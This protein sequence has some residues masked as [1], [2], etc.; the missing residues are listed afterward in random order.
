MLKTVLDAKNGF[1]SLL[2]EEESRKYTDFITEWGVYQYRRGP[3]G[4]H[5][6][7]DAYTRRFYDITSNEEDTL[8]VLMMACYMMLVLKLPSGIPLTISNS[9]QIMVLYSIERNLYLVPNFRLCWF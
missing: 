4:Y 1:H 8:D 6:T 7:G 9:V 5:G 2:I 3:Q